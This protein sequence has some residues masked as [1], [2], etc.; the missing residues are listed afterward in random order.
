M[1]TVAG[2]ASCHSSNDAER[3]DVRISGS[4]VGEM[5]DVNLPAIA[6]LT[7]NLTYTGSYRYPEDLPDVYRDAD[8]NWCGDFADPDGN[9]NWCYPEPDL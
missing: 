5:A 1:Q 8:L 3:V 9:S 2:P 7:P 6:A 4:P